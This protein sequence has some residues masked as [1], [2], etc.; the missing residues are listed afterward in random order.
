M[1]DRVRKSGQVALVLAFMLLGLLFL[2]LVCVDAFLSSH[3]M[4]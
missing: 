1:T 4:Q 3:R 2:A